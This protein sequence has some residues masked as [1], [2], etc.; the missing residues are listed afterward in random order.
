MSFYSVARKFLIGISHIFF[1]F[2]IHGDIDSIP[3]DTG[4]VL[5]ANHLSYLDAVFIAMAFKKQ[6]YFVAK[7]KYADM[8]PLRL[9]FK[10]IGSFGI[11]TEKPDLTAIKNC[12][13]VIKDKKTLAIFPEGTRVIKGRVSNPMPGAIMIAHKTRAPIF[14]IRIAPRKKYFKL[15]VPTDI[16]VGELISVDQLGVTDGKGDQYKKASEKLIEKIYS[17][18]EVCQ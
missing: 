13:R 16:Y 8:F 3:D 10:A 11:N 6:L 1:P 12:F 9:I 4:I 15:F 5:C 14:Y 7:K 18:G 2:K 17:L